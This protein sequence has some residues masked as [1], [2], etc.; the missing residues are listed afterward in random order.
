MPTIWL[1]AVSIST[2]VA[3]NQMK[4]QDVPAA[5]APPVTP[6]TP[7]T[8]PTPPPNNTVNRAP[9][10]LGNA[11]VQTTLNSPIEFNAQFT[12]NNGQKFELAT[13]MQGAL[14]V[15]TKYGMLEILDPATLKVR[16]T[17]GTN[18]RGDDS[19]TIYL[20][21]DGKV[22]STA[23]IK[24][25]VRN[26]LL[27]LKPALVVRATGCVMCHASL[28]SNVI[29]DFGYGDPWFFGGPALAPMDHT[30]I[31]ADESTDP[32]WK[33]VDK[34]GPQVIVPFAPTVQL[35]KVG[36]VTLGAYLRNTL[37]GSPNAQVRNTKVVEMRSVYI[38]A[39]TADR[40][41][42]IGNF[43]GGSLIQ[44]FPD[45][46]QPAALPAIQHIAG[47]GSDYW[48]ND[49]A[50]PLVC[51]GDL[52]IDGVVVL[53]KPVISSQSGCRIYATKSVFVFGPITYSGGDAVNQNLQ[54]VSSRSI[55]FGLGKNTCNAGG[56]G[57]NSLLNRLQGDDRRQ[58][59]F[60]RGEPQKSV[61]QKLDDIVADAALA[62]AV[63]MVDA[64]CEPVNGRNVNFDHVILNAPIVFSRYQGDFRGSIIAE[65]ALMS[66]GAFIFEFDPV[67]SSQVILPLLPPSDY[68]A[69]Q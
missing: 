19:I 22:V 57:A 52:V 58:Y 18:F 34:L 49:P 20:I 66:L 6:S 33:Y 60:T 17:P 16:Y 55:N 48:T 11:D 54:I 38:G 41:R 4:F 37:N 56:I 36:A 61:Q 10:Q 68:L 46:N 7:P 39:P 30:S 29:T 12:F 65:V 13:D 1:A 5:A 3:C 2:S 69:V 23:T 14:T 50:Q 47:S 63:Q 59:Y 53:N 21:Q 32:S 24:V 40:I 64:A 9:S 8:P 28:N 44:Y 43:T 26:P 51:S 67:F 35:G 15:K 31:Y 25:N 27:D 45:A 62:S 42:Q